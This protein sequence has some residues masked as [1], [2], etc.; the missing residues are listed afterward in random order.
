MVGMVA[1]AIAATLL[2]AHC[3]IIS[4]EVLPAHRGKVHPVARWVTDPVETEHPARVSEV[5]ALGLDRDLNSIEM[6]PSC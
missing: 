2:I 3:T 4:A 5:S 6:R 1:R